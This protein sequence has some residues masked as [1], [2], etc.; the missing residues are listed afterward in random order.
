MARPVSRRQ[1]SLP[2]PQTNLSWGAFWGVIGLIG[3]WHCWFAAYDHDEIEHLHASW[4]I[5]VG[6]L[7]YRDFLEQHH[8][9]L[10]F[11]AAPIVAKFAS[12][13]WLVFGAR[14]FDSLC[15]VSVLWLV[16]RLVQRLYPQVR[17]Q[18]PVLLL[19]ASSMF[20]RSTLEFRPDPLMNVALYG[21]LVNWAAFIEEG[22]WWRAFAS[23]A[24]FGVAVVILQK[25]VVVV[26]LLLIGGLFLV[27]LRRWRRQR[28][29]PLVVGLSVVMMV[30]ALFTAELFVAMGSLGIFKEFWFWNYPFNRFFY[31]EAELS[32]HF[33][34]AKTIGLSILLDPVLWIA[35][36]IGAYLCA[37]GLLR[38]DCFS[39]R[40]ECKLWLLWIGIGYFGFL[41]FNRF[42]L[43][44][45]FIVLLPLLALF[46]AELLDSV[47]EGWQA[48][49]LRRSIL[50][51]PL[52]LIAVLLLY[53]SNREQ[54]NVQEFVLRRTTGDQS[55]F[56]P[57]AFNP[58][59]RRD[60]A[61]F[62]YNGDLIS[63]A[64]QEYLRREKNCAGN[65]L[66]LDE[67]RWKATPPAFVFLHLPADQPY[68]WS[69]RE[70]GYSPTRIPSLLK[71][72]DGSAPNASVAAGVRAPQ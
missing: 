57:P 14:I 9:T 36:S 11:L 66:V 3:V 4:L 19:L 39:P 10:W 12:V 16:R 38:R 63:G 51:M 58:I 49:V 33:F 18:F 20:V 24:L 72:D 50:C 62:W 53:P 6:Q 67:H 17:W 41:F 54:L 30:T 69:S 2:N 31:L 70:S 34:V 21:G 15:L 27:V 37:R 64:Y 42:P 7:P 32:Q 55:V 35:G 60:G 71:R 8:P 68:R 22:K 48:V 59:F 13:R 46:A 52:V 43:A 40:D 56:V 44:Q 23:G 45:Y 25:A 5:S 29:R 28:V 65:K 47:R 26:S 1:K 61:Y